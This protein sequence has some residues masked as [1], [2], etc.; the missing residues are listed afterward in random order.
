MCLLLVNIVY[1]SDNICEEPLDPNEECLMIT[2]IITCTGVYDYVIFNGTNNTIEEANLTIYEVGTYYFNFSKP[3]GGYV[4]GLCDGTTREII[5]GGKNKML[6]VVIAI[7]V[8][9]FLLFFA[10]TKINS[11]GSWWLNGAKTLLLITGLIF[12]LLIPSSLISTN[13]E[14]KFWLYVMWVVR[15]YVAY[16]LI[17]LI[18]FA[19]KQW[20]LIKKVRL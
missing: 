10:G 18:S 8:F 15:V 16:G 19:F 1:S 2:P 4:I 14:I 3:S 9:I 11:N 6:S 7:S 5:V 20:D 17:G 13:F 12:M